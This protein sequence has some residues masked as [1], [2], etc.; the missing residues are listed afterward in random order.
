MVDVVWDSNHEKIMS[1]KFEGHVA[2]D[3]GEPVGATG[4]AQLIA[5]ARQVEGT[6]HDA[7]QMTSPQALAVADT[8]RGVATTCAVTVLACAG[9]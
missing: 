6:Y 7:L 4:I 1:L 8:H 3:S 2:K 5:C 9:A